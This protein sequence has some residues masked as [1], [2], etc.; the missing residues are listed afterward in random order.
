MV[1]TAEEAMPEVG[2]LLTGAEVVSVGRAVD[3]GVIEFAG[4]HG[5]VAMVHLQCPF[6]I[7]WSGRLVLGSRDMRYDQPGAGPDAFDRFATVYDGRAATLNDALAQAHPTVTAV[8]VGP[9]GSLT[10][11]WDPEFRL[12]AFPDCSGKVEAWRAFVRGGE[13]HGF[14]PG[15]V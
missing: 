6:R 10:V 3:M 7:V 5:E 2:R 15:T 4:P 14:P 8:T 13:H 1:P 11:T 12:E 9:A